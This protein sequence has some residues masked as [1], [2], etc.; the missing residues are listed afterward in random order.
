MNCACYCMPSVAASSVKPVKRYN[1]LI[2]ELFDNKEPI[3]LQGYL[4]PA[5]EKKVKK[6]YE[7][8]DFLPYRAPKVSRRLARH[9]DKA[10]EMGNWGDVKLAAYSYAVLL[11]RLPPETAL[12]LAKEVVVEHVVRCDAF[13]L[14]RG[15][16]MTRA[17][18]VGR[19][20]VDHC[21][22]A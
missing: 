11:E 9:L 6:L 17:H 1:I 10:L 13:F 7:Y 18:S 22:L 14:S 12:L 20:R 15:C 16:H 19:L 3:Q 4:N 5:V 21:W 8:V 2:K